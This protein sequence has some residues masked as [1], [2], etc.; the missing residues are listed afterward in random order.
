MEISLIMKWTEGNING[1]TVAPLKKYSDERGWLAEIYRLDELKP[2]E[3]PAMGYVSLTVAGSARGPHAH[4]SQTDRFCFAGPGN[5]LVLL[6]D[7]RLDSSTKGNMMRFT[8]GTD[9]PSLVVVPPGV[10][11]GYK[12]ISDIDAF[13]INFPNQLYRGH[14]RKEDVDEI[15]YEDNPE[16]GFEM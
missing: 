8:A 5:F 6:W 16:A 11:H 7:A 14:G 3:A 1:V 12:N 9:S 2:E 10:V 4:I 13:V 15:R